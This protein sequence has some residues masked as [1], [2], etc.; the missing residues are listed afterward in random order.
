[1]RL[2]P[3]RRLTDLAG[4]LGGPN[5]SG[6]LQPGGSLYEGEAF[7][8]TPLAGIVLRPLANAGQ[9]GLGVVW[10]LGTLLLVCALGVLAARAVP[11]LT[12]RR[13]RLVAVPV[14]I[15]LLVLSVP[16]R[17]TFSLGQ[18]SIIP[19]LLV[20]GVVLYGG[21][22]PRAAGALAGLAAALQPS[23]LLFVPLLWLTDR[24]R[25]AV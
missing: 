4:W 17:N 12:S 21:R 7:N 19:V 3:E 1:M 8:G 24:R 10:T 9:Q 20:L 11:G 25:E 6:A 5:G 16:V 18:T 15:S 23:M 14:A 22:A 13:A 2:P